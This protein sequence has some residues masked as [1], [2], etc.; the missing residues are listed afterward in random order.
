MLALGFTLQLWFMQAIHSVDDGV[1]AAMATHSL[2][3]SP[4]LVI[5]VAAGRIIH[6]LAAPSF[7]GP[8]VSAVGGHRTLSVYIFPNNHQRN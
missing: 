3:D 8:T 4:I 1:V 5:N 6:T 2:S 7:S